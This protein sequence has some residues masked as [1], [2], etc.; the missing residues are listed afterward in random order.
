M[1]Q[2]SNWITVT[3]ALMSIIFAY[4]LSYHADYI[5]FL[6]RILSARTYYSD[7]FAWG[8]GDDDLF[9]VCDVTFILIGSHVDIYVAIFLSNETYRIMIWHL[10]R[11]FI[12]GCVV[13]CL[14]LYVALPFL[15]YFCHYERYTPTR[16]DV[17]SNM[18]FCFIA[19][20]FIFFF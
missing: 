13:F 16:Q 8:F 12:L 9:G 10:T 18:L 14:V 15:I 4:G 3:L 2:T 5:N 1:F 20:C 19:F 11:N 6:L 17:F 7:S